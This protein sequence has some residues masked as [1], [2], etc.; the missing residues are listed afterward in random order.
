MN[1]SFPKVKVWWGHR[2]LSLPSGGLQADL[3][4]SMKWELVH[5]AGKATSRGC[6]EAEETLG[7]AP[8][9]PREASPRG[10]CKFYLQLPDWCNSRRGER[11]EREGAA[12]S[13]SKL[14]VVAISVTPRQVA[15]R[16]GA[17]LLLLERGL[18]EPV[19]PV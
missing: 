19:V 2:A 4:G 5:T 13:E 15:W 12:R 1:Q 16:V 11:V 3:V 7:T 17:E 6:R 10:C 8:R 9:D 18:P 14:Q